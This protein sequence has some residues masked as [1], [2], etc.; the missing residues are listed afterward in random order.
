MN[1]TPPDRDLP[2]HDDTMSEYGILAND[3]GDILILQTHEIEKEI[4][5]LEYHKLAHKL[6]FIYADGRAKALNLS[7]NTSME[8]NLILGKKITLMHIEGK[9][10]VNTCSLSLVIQDY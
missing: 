8:K 9:N 3:A 2:Q 5:W 4:E 6:F 1:D 7:I 10:V